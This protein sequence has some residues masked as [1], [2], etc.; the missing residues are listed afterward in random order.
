[1][2][3]LR[4][5]ALDG[6]LQYESSTEEDRGKWLGKGKGILVMPKQIEPTTPA[7]LFSQSGMKP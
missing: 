7:S 1:M 4:L 3:D 2:H 5:K 6:R